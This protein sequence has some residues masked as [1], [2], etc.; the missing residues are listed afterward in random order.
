M[1]YTWYA[2]SL[3]KPF[4]VRK[5][6]ENHYKHS[7]DRFKN[8][9]LK[10]I[11]DNE[12][13]TEQDAVTVGFSGGAD[14]VCLLTVLHDLQRLLR[15]RLQAVHVNHNLRGEEARR[16]EDF[17]R[18]YAENISVPCQAVSIDV[19]GYAAEH[20][21]TEEEAGRILRYEALQERAQ[22]FASDSQG[23]ALIAVAHHA[24]D[25][26]ETVLLNLLRGSGLRGLAGMRARRGNIIRP[27]LGVSRDEI[28]AYLDER[29]ILYVTDS[30]NAE[31]DHTRNR[32]RNIIIPELKS[33]INSAAS[34]HIGLSAS[35]IRDADEYI[36]TEAMHFVDGLGAPETKG[37]IRRLK[38]NQT[39][40]KEKARILRR[41]VIIETLACLGVPLKDW[42]EKHFA[43]IDD[44]LFKHK[45]H[46][47]DLPDGV[48][49]E[50]A[51]K[52]TYLCVKKPQ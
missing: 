44:A 32:L 10:Y 22:E 41:Y 5:L 36:R 16:D 9:I 35:M 46:H 3:S 43:D 39:G 4:A 24:D 11:R 45:G 18:R 6:L 21:L 20:K 12:L 19:H 27:L 15:I 42:G 29:G 50:N 1:A 30:T 25:Q 2:G 40:L 26:A 38:I 51:H 48:Y 7:M 8:K 17:C 52:E 37:D 33:E 23:S 28:I 34:E 31:N 47:V 49:A 14:S 13:L